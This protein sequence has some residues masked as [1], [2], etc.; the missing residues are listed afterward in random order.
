MPDIFYDGQKIGETPMLDP[1]FGTPED[2]GDL[3]NKYGTYNI[4]PTNESDDAFP[5]IAQGLPAQWRDIKIHKEDLQTP[6]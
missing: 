3:I 5:M 1:H 4:Q 6:I 2:V